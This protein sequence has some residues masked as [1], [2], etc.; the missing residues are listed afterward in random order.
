MELRISLPR[1]AGDREGT[2][3]RDNGIV[4]RAGNG[5]GSQSARRW[6]RPEGRGFARL[7]FT[8][9]SLATAEEL[10]DADVESSVLAWHQT[11]LA[12]GAGAML[13]MYDI[14]AETGAFKE[15]SY[16]RI[17]EKLFEPLR[18]KP[19]ALLELGVMEGGSV[20]AWEAYFPNA[21]IAGVDLELPK[22]CVSDRVRLF[23]GDQAD[24]DLLA[25]AAAEV[26]PEGFDIIID[27]CAHIGSAAKASFWYLFENHLKPGGLYSIEDWG[28]GYW[29]TW[30]DG[31]RVV[32]EPDTER[33]M[34][35]HD[36][37]MVGF[38]K[39]LIDELGV[40]DI[41]EGHTAPPPRES[42]FAEML[43]Y[44]GLCIIRKADRL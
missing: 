6:L 4:S 18:G 9:K 1:S 7:D 20:R 43:I 31:R 2:L 24:I 29:P 19:L 23:K 37:G 35:S 10:D 38:I 26:A 33:R 5:N 34:P 8:V 40:A 30:P 3:R 21:R 22:L 15:I 27:D 32:V 16:L 36:A 25:R 17:Y 14:V 39:Q 44:F 13:P 12:K 28:T 41:K 42:K 11:R